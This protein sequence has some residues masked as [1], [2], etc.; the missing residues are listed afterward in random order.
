METSAKLELL[1]S[2]LKAIEYRDV[3]YYHDSI[4]KGDEICAFQHRQGRRKEILAEIIILGL[5][6]KKHAC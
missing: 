5:F 1:I 3:V 2:E 6:V 4:R